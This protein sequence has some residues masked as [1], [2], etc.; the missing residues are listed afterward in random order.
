[1]GLFALAAFTAESKTKEIGVRKAMGASSADVVQLLLWQFTKPVLWANVIAWPLAFWVSS[2]WLHGF[3]YR[4]SLPP[5]LF[6]C[7]SAAALFIAWAAVGT[8]V[9]FVARANP[10][11]ALRYE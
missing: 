10:A 3:A 11:T 7:A 2:H 5:W 4:V 6:L 9:W 1:L 8:Q